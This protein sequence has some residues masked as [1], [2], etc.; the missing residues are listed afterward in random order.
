M[1]CLS[2][3]KNDHPEVF[4]HFSD[5]APALNSTVVLNSPNQ[6]VESN[7]FTPLAAYLGSAR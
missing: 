3:F 1:N 4:V 5:Q 2:V 6:R 7:A